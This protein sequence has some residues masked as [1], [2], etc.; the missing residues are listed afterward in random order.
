M[1]AVTVL[2]FVEQDLS[3]NNGIMLEP[4]WEELQLCT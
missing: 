1:L 2:S 3:K 4:I